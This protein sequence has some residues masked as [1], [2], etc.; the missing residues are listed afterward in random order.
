LGKGSTAA[1]GRLIDIFL[2]NTPQS[3]SSLRS[4]LVQSDAGALRMAAHSL[5]SSS[6]SYGAM[7]LSELCKALEEMARSGDWPTIATHIHQ[8]EM[9]FAQVKH[10][11]EGIRREGLP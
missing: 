7:H 8:V 4:A 11:L 5:K 9:E 10:T 1:L 3:L 6:A 2:E